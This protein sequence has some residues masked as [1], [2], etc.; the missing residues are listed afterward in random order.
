M[1]PHFLAYCHKFVFSCISFILSRIIS[2]YFRSP[3]TASSFCTWGAS[4]GQFV[5]LPL[6]RGG[7]R[8]W[9]ANSPLLSPLQPFSPPAV[10]T[11]CP[12]SGPASGSKSVQRTVSVVARTRWR[13]SCSRRWSGSSPPTS[14]SSRLRRS[15]G[16]HNG[17]RWGTFPSQ[18]SVAGWGAGLHQRGRWGSSST[19]A[20]S[21]PRKGGLASLFFVSSPMPTLDSNPG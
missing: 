21:G 1:F 11:E 7:G 8:R 19:R 18:R 16:M 12:R 2:V 5:P 17:G 9:L 3:P 15:V 14:T 20:E 6:D 4:G 13:R 10:G